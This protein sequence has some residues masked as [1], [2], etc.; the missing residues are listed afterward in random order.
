MLRSIIE[1]HEIV[2]AFNKNGDHCKQI[3]RYASTNTLAKRP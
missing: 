1:R 2:A 3:V